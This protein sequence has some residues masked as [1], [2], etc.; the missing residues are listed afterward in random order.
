ME[1]LKLRSSIILGIILA[2]LIAVV[3]IVTGFSI[4]ARHTAQHMTL[5]DEKN[6]L[7]GMSWIPDK[8][9]LV[10]R[11]DGLPKAN[12]QHVDSGDH[13]NKRIS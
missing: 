6:H 8:E 3:G 13:L 1:V 4:F 11:N 2:A 7:K 10:K 12:G 5:T 9:L